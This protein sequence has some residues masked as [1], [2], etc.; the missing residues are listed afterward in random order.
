MEMV[1]SGLMSLMQ[2]RV[3]FAAGYE[4]PAM[5]GV[6]VSQVLDHRLQHPLGN[7]R[8]GGTVQINDRAPL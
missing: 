3:A 4:T 6:V 5:I 7:L 8:A 2:Q 1:G